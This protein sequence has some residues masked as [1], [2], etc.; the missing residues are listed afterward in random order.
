MWGWGRPSRIQGSPGTQ[1]ALSATCSLG[2]PASAG[3][4]HGGAVTMLGAGEDAFLARCLRG[5]LPASP[6]AHVSGCNLGAG[7]GCTDLARCRGEVEGGHSALWQDT[8]A[9]GPAVDSWGWGCTH[10][11]PTQPS[12]QVF[13][14][15][16]HGHKRLSGAPCLL[17]W[18]P[19]ALGQLPF[20]KMLACSQHAASTPGSL[21][22]TAIIGEFPG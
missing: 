10:L 1:P 22:N 2:P 12:W 17:I 6:Q 13:G 21:S 4:R 18:P 9:Q 8:G 16:P 15:A 5:A 11:S 14:K 19:A 20:R 3:E 7:L